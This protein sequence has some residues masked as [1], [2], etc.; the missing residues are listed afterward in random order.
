MRTTLALRQ[1]GFTAQIAVLVREARVLMGWSQRELAARAATSQSMV[2]RLER[3]T[4]P[5]LDLPT[6]EHVLDALGL[7]VTLDIAGR[8]LDDRRRQDDAVHAVV[9][10]FAARRLRSHGWRVAT[11]V[12]IGD[13]QPRGW[14]DLLAFRE[15]DASL[16]VEES[17]TDIVDAGGLMRQV[18]FYEKEA[19]RAARRL[20]WRPARVRVL[21][22]A[23]DSCRVVERMRDNRGILGTAFPA[24]VRDTAA[25]IK[26]PARPAP[27]GWTLA[28]AD[29]RSR[30]SAWLHAPGLT[31]R[32]RGS[33]FADYREAA[34]LLV[35]GAARR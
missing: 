2:S 33:A 23:L 31:G 4:A 29:P 34:A 28:V 21:V 11:E 6:V 17:K 15:H 16:L 7:R 19:E 20:G 14:I 22:V 8:H 12:Q 24:P 27:I 18:A 1:P 26:D 9:T 35:H 25:W 10:G 32:V 5:E 13:A 30:G 3:G